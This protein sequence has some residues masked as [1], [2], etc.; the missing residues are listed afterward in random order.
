[1]NRANRRRLYGPAEVPHPAFSVE[2]PKAAWQTASVVRRGDFGLARG[3]GLAGYLTRLGTFG[4]YGHACVAVTDGTV[5][6]AGPDGQPQSDLYIVEAQGNG[7]RRRRANPDEFVWSRCA[8]T[9]PQRNQIVALAEVI[10]ADRT[11]Y[12]YESIVAFAGRFLGVRVRAGWRKLI[13]R[14]FAQV[15]KDHR[16][17]RMICSAVVEACYRP[18]GHELAAS[19][20]TQIGDVSP[21]DLADHMVRSAT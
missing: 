3:G 7:A 9:D 6:G 21:N 14:E 17:N 13:Q 4:R 10:A 16:P 1:M 11:P 8:L 2:T 12:D 5:S 15:S 18:A 20:A 19:P